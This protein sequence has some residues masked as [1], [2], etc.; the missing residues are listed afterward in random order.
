MMWFWKDRDVSQKET[1]VMIE[2]QADNPKKN[3]KIEKI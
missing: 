1:E 2:R 3:T